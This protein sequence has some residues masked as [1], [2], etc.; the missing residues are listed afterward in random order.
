M[1]FMQWNLLFLCSNDINFKGLAL[2]NSSLH[3]SIFWALKYYVIITYM[4]MY[5]YIH[6]LF[7]HACV[8][9]LCVYVLPVQFQWIPKIS[10]MEYCEKASSSLELSTMYSARQEAFRVWVKSSSHCH[11]LTNY[12]QQVDLTFCWNSSCYYNVLWIIKFI[13]I[14]N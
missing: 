13:I 3:L 8:L 6:R 1:F 14:W 10:W 5:M 11:L 9:H 7:M 12:L 2:I 4:N